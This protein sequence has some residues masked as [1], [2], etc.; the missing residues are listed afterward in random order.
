MIILGKPIHR[1]NHKWILS[2]ILLG[3]LYAIIRTVI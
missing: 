3:V 1:K 2:I